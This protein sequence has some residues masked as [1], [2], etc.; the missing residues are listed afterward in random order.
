MFC[1]IHSENIKQRLR[2]AEFNG[3]MNIDADSFV[4]LYIFCIHSF[5][6]LIVYLPIYLSV[7]FDSFLCTG[8]IFDILGNLTIPLREKE[9][10]DNIC[11][12]SWRRRRKTCTF[13][14]ILF[15][16]RCVILSSTNFLP[17]LQPPCHNSRFF[18]RNKPYSTKVYSAFL[19]LSDKLGLLFRS[20]IRLLRRSHSRTASLL[21]S[22]R[23][24]FPFLEGGRSVIENENWGLVPSACCYL[25]R[26]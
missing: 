13:R 8:T 6:S 17:K 20:S 12:I 25:F 14:F 21:L 26:G 1:N 10:K 23:L 11:S 5:I 18:R 7:Y 9:R 4:Y 24:F 3:G 22:L 15:Y 19:A 2:L 16:L